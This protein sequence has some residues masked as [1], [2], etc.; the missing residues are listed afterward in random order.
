MVSAAHSFVFRTF[1]RFPVQSVRYL[2]CVIVGVFFRIGVL[3]PGRHNCHQSL[4]LAKVFG[5]TETTRV[6]T[7]VF[8]TF[9]IFD[10]KDAC[11]QVGF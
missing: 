1:R 4:R 2:M 7:C 5:S 10:R 8:R 11:H 6:N 3:W 9:R